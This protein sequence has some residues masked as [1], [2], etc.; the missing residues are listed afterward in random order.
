MRHVIPHRRDAVQLAAGD[1]RW[2]CEPGGINRKLR[3]CFD[4]SMQTNAVP[5]LK[6]YATYA[7]TLP[8]REPRQGKPLALYQLPFY[9]AS[10][11]LDTFAKQMS[12]ELAQ[13]STVDYIAAASHSGK[14]ASVLVGFL[15]SREGISGDK[16]LEF[17][18]YLYMPFSNNAGNFH[19]NCVDDEE[20]LVSACGQSPKK[21]EALGACYMRDCLRA[22]VSE[23]EYV[24]VWNPPDTIPIFK[25]TAKVL[26]E[27]VSTFMQRS[28]KGVLLVH[29]DEHRS[30]CP[31]PDFCRGALR[32]LA[33]LPSVQVLA[34]Y[35]DIPPLPGQKSSETC[36]RPIACLLPDVKTI[37]D[38]RLQMCFLDLMDEAVLLHVAT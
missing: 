24:D 7:A 12:C 37:M 19:S 26:Q 33:E 3:G 5:L 20:L 11:D 31:D 8:V 21:R 17:T 36:R 35:T 22:Q 28:P 38:E 9:V 10:V 32:V 29:V 4:E 16:A 15:R 27:D 34:T 18:H 6:D 25:A 13:R 30:M 2:W 14:S 23:G 1:T